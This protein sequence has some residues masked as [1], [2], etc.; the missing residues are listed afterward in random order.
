[1][2]SKYTDCSKLTTCMQIAR[3]Y[4]N[5]NSPSQLLKVFSIQTVL[6]LWRAN[7]HCCPCLWIPLVFGRVFP[8]AWDITKEAKLIGSSFW[9]MNRKFH[10]FYKHS[11]QWGAGRLGDP[12]QHGNRC[13]WC[14]CFKGCNLNF[15]LFLPMG[16]ER[17]SGPMGARLPLLHSLR[18]S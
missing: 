11:E 15:V 7:S 9:E 13:R 1:M 4:A 5:F 10:F 2:A 3:C 14:A 17:A 8:S 18:I 12:G 6:G 16:W